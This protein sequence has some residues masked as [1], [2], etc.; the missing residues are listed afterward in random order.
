M[1]LE[2]W[3]LGT[4]NNIRELNLLKCLKIRHLYYFLIDI[5]F[6]QSESRRINEECF[7]KLVI[8]LPLARDTET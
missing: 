4:P 2:S 1:L 8:P 3:T 5:C 7:R 6:V